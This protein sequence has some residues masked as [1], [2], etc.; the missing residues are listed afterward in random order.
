[1]GE[2][3]YLYLASGRLPNQTI[4]KFTA[5]RILKKKKTGESVTYIIWNARYSKNAFKIQP[6]NGIKYF[7][8]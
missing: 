4:L 1:M 3:H 8:P 6:F 2:G 5:S 7:F